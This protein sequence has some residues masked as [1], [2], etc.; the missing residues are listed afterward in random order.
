[1]RYA[2]EN[3][4]SYLEPHAEWNSLMES[5]VADI[6]GLW[7]TFQQGT[8]YPGE[9]N[10]AN[11]TVE[12]KNGTIIVD[13]W[14][15]I[16]QENQDTGPLT[17]AGDFYNYFVLGQVPVGYEEAGR[18]W[19]DRGEPGDNQQ[20][21]VTT[22]FETNCGDS[23]WCVRSSAAFNLTPAVEQG[24]LDDSNDELITGYILED[25]STAVLS[26]PHFYS[27]G[28]GG[29]DTFRFAIQDLILAAQEKKAKR[30]IID[31]QQNT[32]GSTLRAYDTFKL[33]FPSLEPYGASRTR[34]HE[35]AETLGNTYTKAFKDGRLDE[36]YAS[37]EWVVS[38]RI[39]ADQ[40]SRFSS[41]A[42]YF[43]GS[44]NYSQPV[45]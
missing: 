38:N 15:A 45:R 11:L 20:P 9:E 16:Y 31:V 4:A 24:E 6:L 28:A 33:F 29:Y 22:P 10:D 23:V 42:N 21:P 39:H 36:D 43:S 19:P 7:S 18:W 35:W 12:L 17:T 13:T 14:S 32:G 40:N 44:S 1:M 37:S 8:I 41:W 30:I 34:K 3:A 25:I 2:E 27:T 26:I 5:P